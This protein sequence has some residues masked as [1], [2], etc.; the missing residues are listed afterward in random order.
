MRGKARS[1][2]WKTIKCIVNK[3]SI[4]LLLNQ[5]KILFSLSTG[6]QLIREKHCFQSND[7]K[8]IGAVQ[9]L[10]P[11]SDQDR[12]SPYNIKQTSD[13]IK[14][15]YILGDYWLIPYQM[16]WTNITRFIWQKVRRITK[17]ILGVRGLTK[18][19]IHS[20]WKNLIPAFLTIG[21]YVSVGSSRYETPRKFGEY[22]RCVGVA[23]G[24]AESNSSFSSVLQTS[25][26]LHISMNAQL[27]YEPILL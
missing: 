7:T 16:L 19:C 10:T 5:L 11:R 23:G 21:S 4:L 17:E 18:K 14:E 27:M 15:R 22:E 20:S 12:I 1:T 8:F 25:Q 24:V 26:V 9:P 6:K 2:S 13:E 3:H